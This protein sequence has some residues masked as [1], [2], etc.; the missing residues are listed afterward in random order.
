VDSVPKSSSVAI[1]SRVKVVIDGCFDG[2]PISVKDACIIEENFTDASD[3]PS[4]SLADISGGY[5]VVNLNCLFTVSL[6]GSELSH[7]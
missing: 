6:E 1:Q 3:V 7:V 2:I 5:S 4:S